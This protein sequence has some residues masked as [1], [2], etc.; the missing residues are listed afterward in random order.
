MKLPNAIRADFIG[1]LEN[2]CLN[3][4]HDR[5]KDKARLFQEKLGI[6]LQNSEILSAALQNAIIREEATLHK[7]N[8]YGTYYNLRF[9]LK[10]EI[11]E[12]WILSA[13]IVRKS[14]NFPR[15][16]SCYPVKK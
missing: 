14:E 12:S 11:G 1:K 10:T 7:N 13:W 3:P 9:F 16:V 2:Y 4:H 5:G 6:T 8:D 15:L